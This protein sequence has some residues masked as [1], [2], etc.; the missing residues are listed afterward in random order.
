MRFKKGFTLAEILIVL[1]V[2]GVI[3]TMTIPSIMKGTTEAQLKTGY[4]KAF[5]T[6]SSFATTESLTGS[7]PSTNKSDQTMRL[8]ESLNEYLTVAGYMSKETI[9]V[10]S[11]QV[12]KKSDYVN[13]ITINGNVYG[14]GDKT[15]GN[16]DEHA[17]TTFGP[18]PW[19]ITDD[20]MAYSI[21]CGGQTGVPAR[22][23]TKEEIS[24]QINQT[25][26][27]SSSC[28][29]IIVDVNG[30]SKGPNTYEP[31]AGPSDGVRLNNME[32]KLANGGTLKTLTGDQYIIFLGLN[33]ASAGPKATSVGGRIMA[34]LK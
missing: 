24:N 23:K 22:C 11:G 1:M 16:V 29:I 27:A 8:F 21:M 9:P 7:L 3:S 33:G 20:N 18:S 14:S 12:A 34:D 17:I 6:I 4:K 30:L 13:S 28:A 25:N 5:N 32:S 19:I 26:A 10:N 2:I 15:A 31:Q